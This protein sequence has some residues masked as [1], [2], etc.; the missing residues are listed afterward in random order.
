LLLLL[1][2]D[3]AP[4]EPIG[5]SAINGR[6]VKPRT[7]SS[8]GGWS[9]TGLPHHEHWTFVIAPLAAGE[10]RIEYESFVA[11]D[12]RLAS[13]WIIA[14][15]PGHPKASVVALPQPERI[16]LGGATLAAPV[17]IADL[18]A[19]T[20]TVDRPVERINGVF[21]DALTPA[22]IS[23]G[24]GTLQKNQSVWEKPMIIGSRRYQRGLGTHAPSK[25]VYSLDGKYRRFQTWAGADANTAP[26]ITFEVRVD[27]VVRWKQGLTTRD[28]PAAWVDLDITGAKTLELHVG[29]NGEFSADHADWAEAR[30]LR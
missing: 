19:A 26:T 28:T 15:K 4:A 20:A 6:P 29:D 24:Y 8:A 9:A 30:L 12:T 1:E 10:N 27:G 16:S 11:G 7:A 22:S 23:Q 17:R 2:G 5:K 3:K 18:S 13:A 21:L 25:I 14:G